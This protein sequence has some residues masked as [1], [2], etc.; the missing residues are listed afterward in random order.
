MSLQERLNDDLKTAMRG[1]DTLARETLRMV[2]AA[3]KNR[4]IEKGEDLDDADVQSVL[5][6]E[7]KKREDAASQFEQAGRTELAEKEKAEARILATYLPEKLDEGATKELLEK[8]IAELGV[9]SKK[10]M[11][12]LMKALSAGHKGQVDMKLAQKLIGSLLS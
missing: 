9:S 10:E 5:E 1:G 6:K 3:T 8:L 11:G 2:L 7:L 4:R 12:K